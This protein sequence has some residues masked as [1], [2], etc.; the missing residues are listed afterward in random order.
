MDFE[1]ICM[2][3]T[4]QEPYYGILLSAMERVS[5]PKVSTLGVG[6]AGNVFKLYY[7]PSFVNRFSTDTVIQLLK[8]EV[9][10]VAFN[11][12]TI[13]NGE[14]LHESQGMHTM[15]NAALDLE[16]NGYIDR[17]VMD[18]TAGGVWPEDFGWE[19]Y[20]G[21]REYFR[22][23]IQM[24]QDQQQQE[25]QAQAQNPKQ[26]CDGGLGGQS[27]QPSSPQTQ[28]QP[29]SQSQSTSQSQPQQSQGQQSQ[30]SNGG[31]QP[32]QGQGQGQQQ[33]QPQQPNPDE[34]SEQMEEKLSQS[35]DDH[36]EWPDDDDESMAEQLK[37]VVD[38]LLVFAEEEVQKSHGTIPAEMVGRLE[39]IKKKKPKPVADWKRYFRRYLGNEFS[40]FIRKSKKRES[41]R[42]PDAAGNRHRRKSHILVAIDTSDSVSM[43][44][45]REFFGQIKTLTATADFHVLECDA[46][47]QHEYD[48]KGRP[49]EVLHGGGGTDFQP[50]VDYYNEHRKLYDALVYFT[51]GYCNIP[52]DTPKDTLWVVSSQG[53]Q[54]DRK[55][56]RVNGASVAFIP[57]PKQ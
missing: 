53:D 42:F 43:P 23:I 30:P 29:Q 48:F 34:L 13:W 6:R 47:I 11:H 7:N 25:Q 14:D 44:E 31:G 9:L 35:F 24:N 33:P 5:T 37:Q 1:K 55:K 54:S 40:E 22:R 57:K 45:Y 20:A 46:R 21:A 52:A 39:G 49:S 50:V 32:Q 28:T 26:P 12:F 27:Q 19:K 36:S 3:F 18:K 2:M 51:D 17:S 16:I 38:D 15:R 56:Y 4:M 10:H 8:H 41:R